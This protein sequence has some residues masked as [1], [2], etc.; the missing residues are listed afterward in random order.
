MD[1][2]PS[3]AAI[4]YPPDSDVDV[5]LRALAERLAAAGFR[6]GGVVQSGV[7]GA[8]CRDMALVDLSS[9]KRSSIAQKLGP[10]ST[11]CKLDTAVMADV[12]GRLERQIDAGLDLMILNR[13][14]K[15]EIDG[16]GFRSTVERAMLRSVPL[17][18]AVRLQ[19]AEAWAAFHGGLGTTLPAT[20]AA[21]DAWAAGAIRRKP[22][23]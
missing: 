22:K 15:V 3:L 16:G 18:T 11:S 19:N 6:V 12:A 2:S 14:G 9:G 1:H 21:L 17:L 10:L 13:F 8:G 4:L 20:A 7:D 5:L 23:T